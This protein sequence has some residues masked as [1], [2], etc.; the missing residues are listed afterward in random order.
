MK[1]TYNK[2]K[3]GFI[4]TFPPK[5]CGVGEYV[6][7]LISSIKT[8][9]PE[10]DLLVFTDRMIDSDS[11]NIKNEYN[12]V[13]IFRSILYY[14]TKSLRHV[15]QEVQSSGGVDIIHVQHEYNIFGSD[16]KIIDLLSEAKKEKIVKKIVFTLHTV[17]DPL[18]ASKDIAKFQE[19]VLID[20]DA[21]IFHN[22]SQINVF[23]RQK[24]NLDKIHVIPHGS[25][26]NPY[27]DLPREFIA[28]KFHFDKYFSAKT[29]L[30]FIGFLR[31]D[32]GLETLL[33]ALKYIKDSKKIG[34]I[35]SGEPKDQF[36]MKLLETSE[37]KTIIIPRYLSLKEIFMLLSYSDI[38]VLPYNDP[39]GKYAISG[40]F[41]LSVGSMKPIIGSN[42]PRLNELK[43]ITP[44]LVFEASNPKDLY[45]IIY[46]I[47]NS[48]K[49]N[50]SLNLQRRILY[51]YTKNTSW[52]KVA[53]KHLE[54][55]HKI[56][57]N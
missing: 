46:E 14:D 31:Q 7:F 53:K 17:F 45:S 30:G 9:N 50:M 18:I 4:S 55:Y 11:F 21:L 42:V 34:L 28:R 49:Y 52:M 43:N 47:I 22:P 41:H 10:I 27:I 2:L 15:L 16:S 54:L 39:Q 57:S 20:A 40:M 5:H 13:K 51:S 24:D 32:K 19:N 37:V 56:L 29:I 26:I 23:K 48:N 3:I 1:Y 33:E 25:S 35:V 6:K 12:I 38:I 36:I 8:L 44:N